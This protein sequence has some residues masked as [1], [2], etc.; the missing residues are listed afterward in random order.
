MWVF[1]LTLGNEGFSMPQLMTEK[2]RK[3][4]EKYIEL[5]KKLNKATEE[6]SGVG[7]S[8]E[9]PLFDSVFALEDFATNLLSETIGD[10]FQFLS[11]FLYE[12]ECGKKGLKAGKKGKMKKIKTI[13]DFFWLI[14][15]DHENS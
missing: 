9:C 3:K 1:L 5:H 6:L 15:G 12:N 14:K 2:T 13:E 7:F 8:P 4:L 11:W 10:D